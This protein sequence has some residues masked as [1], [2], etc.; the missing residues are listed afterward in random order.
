MPCSVKRDI[1][2]SSDR[3]TGPDAIKLARQMSKIVA[4]KGKKSLT[5]KVSETPADKELAA[6]ILGPTGNLR[7][8]TLIKGKTMIVGFT[9][10]AYSNL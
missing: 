8:P 1:D 6:A 3:I 9:P 7:A 4:V 10:E 5:I 2:A